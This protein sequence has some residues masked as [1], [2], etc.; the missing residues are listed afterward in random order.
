VASGRVYVTRIFV[1]GGRVYWTEG[2]F[3]NTAGGFY[4][5]SL[6]GTGFV[7]IFAGPT[8]NDG[9]WSV[10]TAQGKAYALCGNG[11]GLIDIRQCTLPCGPASS[12]VLTPG[13]SHL[14]YAIA[15]DPASGKVFYTVGTDYNQLPNG[16]VFDSAG[17]RVGNASQP[18]PLDVVVA[19]GSLYWLNDGTF[20]A[21]QYLYNAS[22]KRASLASLTNEVAVTAT[23]M[24]HSQFGR[25]A[26][27]AFGVYFTDDSRHV[28]SASAT[29]IGAA[30]TV[31]DSAGGSSVATDGMNVYFDDDIGNV[32]RYCQR[33]AG[34]GAG[35]TVL[36]SES[37]GAVTLDANSVIYASTTRIRRVAKP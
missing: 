9:C 33:G 15:A 24:T 28:L 35:G 8:A 30:P 3:S 18:N 4:S 37:A 27:D 1:D 2:P 10:A 25:L 19:N 22:V 29:A 14:A 21:D 23:D 7:T 5:E 17:N 6:D 26:V 11:G 36:A 12:T 16:G 31:F 32:L 20:T 34:C 13:L